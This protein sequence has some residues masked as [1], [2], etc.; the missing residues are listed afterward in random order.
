MKTPFLTAIFCISAF[1]FAQN[2]KVTLL[3]N[4]ENTQTFIAQHRGMWMLAPENSIPALQY[5]IDLGADILETDVR[6]T[7]DNQLIIMHD[8]SVDRT[9]NGTGKVADLTLDEIK[10]L[11][12]KDATGGIT[13]YQVPT[14]QE[15]ITLAKGKI[16]LYYDKA[17]YDLPHHPKGYLVQQILKL[18]DENHFL[19]ESLFV[20]NWDYSTAKTIFGNR[21]EKVL[22]CPVIEDSIVNLENYTDEFLQKLHP[23]AFQF[24]F[25]STD[26]KTYKLLPKILNAKSRAFVAATWK[27]HTANHDDIISI[28]QSPEKGWGWLL[29][30]GFSILETNHLKDLKLFL[31]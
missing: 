8:T 28:T 14:L 25:A 15:F 26:S 3:K 11:R 23:I 16:I 30:Q 20:L 31:K 4:T 1:I 9:T 19:E 5:A 7:K 24:R 13:P 10:K 17:G 18:A 29:K 12:L 21:L 6:L 27:H 2:Q 22:Y